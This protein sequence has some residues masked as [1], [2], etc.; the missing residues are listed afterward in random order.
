SPTKT[1]TPVDLIGDLGSLPLASRFAFGLTSPDQR[2]ATRPP[3]VS[4]RL[5]LSND[6][7]RLW[8]GTGDDHRL[9]TTPTRRAIQAGKPRPFSIGRSNGP[10]R[11]MAYGT[12]CQPRSAASDA[13][14]LRKRVTVG[15]SPSS[16]Q[17]ALMASVGRGGARLTN[18]TPGACCSPHEP[19]V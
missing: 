3:V 12:Y 15:G 17:T 4:K 8:M 10:E 16:G 7:D 18:A 9:P 5:W 19:T 14:A 1:G 6:T 2:N 13:A 11:G